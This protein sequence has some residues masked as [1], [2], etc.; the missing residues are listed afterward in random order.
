[1]TRVLC[2]CL[3]NICRSP[4]AHG[5]LQHQVAQRGLGERVQVDSAGT[6]AYHTG[7]RPDPRTRDVLARNGIPLDT[8][9]RQVRDS[10]FADFDWVLAM[11]DANHRDLLRRCPERYRDR[12]RMVLEPVGGGEVADPYYG[13]GD[14]FE[15]NFEQL[16]AAMEQWLD[17]IVA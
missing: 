15:R 4:M 3:G 6:A 11:D 1:M 12:V 13:G 2:V 7:E 14:G 9:A 17:R 5:I 16:T 10:D 8:T